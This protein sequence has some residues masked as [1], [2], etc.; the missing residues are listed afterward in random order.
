LKSLT[1]DELEHMSDILGQLIEMLEIEETE[2]FPVISADGL[3]D[4]DGLSSIE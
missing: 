1:P 3:L 2:E 4:G